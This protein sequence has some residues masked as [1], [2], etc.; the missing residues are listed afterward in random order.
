MN[1]DNLRFKHAYHQ[2]DIQWTL[3]NP[4]TVDRTRKKIIVYLII[5]LLSFF[6]VTPLS[7]YS[8]VRPIQKSFEETDL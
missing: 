2:D 5:L 1:L 4:D 3:L 6:L 7:I 8:V